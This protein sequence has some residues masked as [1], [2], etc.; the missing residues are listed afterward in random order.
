MENKKKKSPTSWAV[1]FGAVVQLIRLLVDLCRD[2][3]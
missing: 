3:Q 1:W 2:H